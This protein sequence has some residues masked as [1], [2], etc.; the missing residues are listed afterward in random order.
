M[1]STSHPIQR[2]LQSTKNTN[3]MRNKVAGSVVAIAKKGRLKK[4]TFW[5]YWKSVCITVDNGQLMLFKNDKVPLIA[6][7]IQI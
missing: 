4:R 2:T 3:L 7:Q 5:E 6:L 1:E